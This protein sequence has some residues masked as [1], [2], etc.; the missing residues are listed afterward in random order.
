MPARAG[1]T[2]LAIAV[3]A[4]QMR[5]IGQAPASTLAVTPLFGPAVGGDV[6]GGRA[7]DGTGLVWLLAGGTDLVRVDL[8]ARRAHRVALKIAPGDQCWGLARLRDG[9]LWTLKGRRTVIRI[10]PD[11]VIGQEIP[12]PGPHLG[13]FASGDRLVYQPADFT[14]PAPALKSGIPGDDPQPWSGLTTRGFEALARGSAVALNM[15]SC[16]SSRT[17]ERACWFP[18]EAAVA[19]IDPSGAT[20][21]MPL[22]GLDVVAPEVLLVSA[23]PARPV[24]D[25]YV[26]EAGVLWVLSSGTPPAGAPDL[27][28]GW[29]LARYTA[30]GQ[31]LDIRRL[32][33]PARLILRA[34]SGRATVLT[35][36]G[37]VA[38]VTP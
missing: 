1:V 21:R 8:D 14:P 13:L 30:A 15:V 9:S 6:I 26:D 36:A 3:G 24:R 28:G 4:C 22:S 25:A 23:N 27:P 19:L 17:A 10:E 12:L 29:I 38:Q 34:M 32:A 35:G 5:S 7:A 31:L 18:D 16:G 33:E 37:M 2:L 11:G 20:R